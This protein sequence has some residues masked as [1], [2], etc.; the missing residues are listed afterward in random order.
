MSNSP[1]EKGKFA[2]FVSSR[3]FY[4]AIAVCLAGAGIATWIAVERTI[5]DI[6]NSNIQ[7]VES[8]AKHWELPIPVEAEK[9]ETKKH[10]IPVENKSPQP[11]S[12][13]STP[14]VSSVPPV[15]ASSRPAESAET[16]KPSGERQQLAKLSYSL[17]V[18]GDIINPFSEGALVKNITLRD[19]RTH[20]GIDIA[21]E[22]GTEV[23]ASAEGVVLE[24]KHDVLWGTTVTIEHIDGR[25]TIYMGLSDVIPVTQGENVMAK[26]VIGKAEGIPCEAS[27]GCHLHFALKENGAWANP[28]SL[29][30]RM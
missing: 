9:A 13:T 5:A 27:D 25:Q 14:S 3:G 8:E 29:I 4:A 6:E 16:S 7:I 28:L 18:K 15:T 19:W 1:Y 22:K 26:Q 11:S 17:P 23:I 30:A 10:D 21:C 20:D 24:V 12:S 2:K